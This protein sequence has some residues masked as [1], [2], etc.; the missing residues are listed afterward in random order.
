[1]ASIAIAGKEVVTPSALLL[2][3]DKAELISAK[4]I[5]AP[6]PAENI[7][8]VTYRIWDNDRSD[9][10]REITFDISATG[11]SDLVAGFG[12]TLENRLEVDIWQDIQT[13]F[14]LVP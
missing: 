6:D 7:C 4:F 11:F 9:L 2:N 3:S 8:R 10:I 13:K 14:E 12:A 1:M 5:W